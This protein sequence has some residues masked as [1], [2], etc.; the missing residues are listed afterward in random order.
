V[1]PA[2]RSL[3]GRLGAHTL[4]ARNG[5]NTGPARV[6]F[7]ARFYEGIPED[8]PQAERDRRAEHARKAHFARLALRSAQ[9]R[10][11]R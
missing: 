3:R 4:H 7:N 11:R 10:S 6:A 8:L 9:V 2:E 5:T 1:T